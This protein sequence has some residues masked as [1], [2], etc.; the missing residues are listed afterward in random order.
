MMKLTRT[1]VVVFRRSIDNDGGTYPPELVKILGDMGHPNVRRYAVP[2]KQQLRERITTMIE[3]KFSADFVLNT[4]VDIACNQEGRSYLYGYMERFG[5]KTPTDSWWKTEDYSLDIKKTTLS[6]VVKVSAYREAIKQTKNLLVLTAFIMRKEYA[7]ENR[8]QDFIL[9]AI[10]KL[11]K[12][13]NQSEVPFLIP[14]IVNSLTDTAHEELIKFAQ[15]NGEYIVQGGWNTN[16]TGPHAYDRSDPMLVEAVKR[17][18]D[19]KIAVVTTVWGPWQIYTKYAY[20]DDDE[21]VETVKGI[22]FL[23]KTSDQS[24][25]YDPSAITL[26]DLMDEKCNAEWFGLSNRTPRAYEPGYEPGYE[27]EQL[28]KDII[29]NLFMFSSGRYVDEL[30]KS[31]WLGGFMR[32]E[33]VRL[34]VPITTWIYKYIE[35][36]KYREPKTMTSDFYTEEYVRWVNNVREIAGENNDWLED[37]INEVA[38]GPEF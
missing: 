21:G 11:G 29:D 22:I 28:L 2:S 36:S 15:N 30:M 32:K 3:E 16:S 1:E 6:N 17:C 8:M 26:N 25:L 37:A 19:P 33:D 12:K 23:D 24:L 14:E 34:T 13:Q 5:V 10:K 18:N 35:E 38:N 4:L 27:S 31:N 7:L 20:Y 9:G